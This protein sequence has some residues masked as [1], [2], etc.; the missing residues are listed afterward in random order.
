MLRHY[1]GQRVLAYVIPRGGGR[2]LL[3]PTF[4]TAAVT[5]VP[6]SP[7]PS[8]ARLRPPTLSSARRRILLVLLKPLPTTASSTVD[9][10]VSA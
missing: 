4:K 3:S 1:D 5:T 2:P 6:L 7:H 10:H 9:V 8:S